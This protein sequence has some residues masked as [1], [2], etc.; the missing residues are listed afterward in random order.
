MMGEVKFGEVKL[1]QAS[2]NAGLGSRY[3]L[4]LAPLDTNT[5]RIVCVCCSAV[6]GDKKIFECI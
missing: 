5:T 1:M 2:S 3:I 4:T 6:R